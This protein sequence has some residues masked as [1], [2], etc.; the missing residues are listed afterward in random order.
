MITDR[1]L[2]D[3]K[4]QVEMTNGNVVV[5]L[6]MTGIDNAEPDSNSFPNLITE[7]NTITGAFQKR[8]E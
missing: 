5:N 2:L 1:Q 3:S 4:D 6:A 7:E 8:G